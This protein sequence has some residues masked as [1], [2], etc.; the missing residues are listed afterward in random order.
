MV[1]ATYLTTLSICVKI[2]KKAL[3]GGIILLNTD[4]ICIRK[5]FK[6]KNDTVSFHSHNYHELVYYTY[7]NGQTEINNELYNFSNNHFFI[8]PPGVL[9]NEVHNADAEVICI[10]FETE[11]DL[12]LAFYT[13]DSLK[14]YYTLKDLLYEVKHQRY[15]YKDMLILKLNELFLY[16]HRSNNP[17]VNEKNFEYVINYIQENSRFKIKLKDCAKQLN[18]SYDYFQHK[19]KELTGFSPMQ[20]LINKRLSVSKE[21]LKSTDLS[22]TEIAFRS[23]FSTSAQYSAIFKKEF[24]ISPLKYRKTHK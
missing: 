5:L 8:I 18:I 9:H 1:I 20:F 4:L 21:L 14:C 24:G 10:E 16:I 7:G 6:R 15:G 19:F 23:G 13:D 17:N 12:P 22:C 2:F 3:I 11:Q